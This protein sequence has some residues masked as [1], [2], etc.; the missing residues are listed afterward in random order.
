MPGGSSWHALA[1]TINLKNCVAH[2]KVGY[3]VIK[4]LRYV[5]KVGGALA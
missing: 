5:I 2:C 1:S 3:C 4:E